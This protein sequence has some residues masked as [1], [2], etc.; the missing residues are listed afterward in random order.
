MPLRFVKD[1]RDPPLPTW[2]QYRAVLRKRDRTSLLLTAAQV[3][4]GLAGG[5]DP[6]EDAERYGFTHWS[7]GDVARMSL[8]WS[9]DT[10]P[11][12]EFFDLVQLSSMHVNLGGEGL[13]PGTQQIENFE[14]TMARILFQQAVWQRSVTGELA[15]T[16]LLFGE[17]AEFPGAYNVEVMT[18][19]WF[20]RATDGLTLEEY[21][22]AIF[23]ISATAIQAQ[24]Q[25][26]PDWPGQPGLDVVEGVFSPH[27]LR[28]VFEEHLVTTADDFKAT[29]RT[30]QD[31]L[32]EVQK[33]YA[34]NPLRDTPF[35]IGLTEVPFAPWVQAIMMKASP[36]GI[37][38]LLHDAGF[39]GFSND[40]GM[41][42]QEYVGRH[43]G[44]VADNDRVLSEIE[45]G[46]K[47]NRLDSCDWFLDLPGLL[48]LIECK[49][50]QPIESLRVAD[51]SWLDAITR[52]VGRGIAQ[53][54]RSAA[55]IEAINAAGRALDTT[56]PRIGLVVTLEPFFLNQLWVMR[57]HL[58]PAEFP[59]GVVSIED[60]ERL[61]T[62][63]PGELA[64][65]LLADA[66]RAVD[67]VL[68]LNESMGVAQQRG[69][70]NHLIEETFQSLGLFARVRDA[71]ERSAQSSVIAN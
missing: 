69:G 57:A 14:R 62:L 42:F 32:D 53:L 18:P 30:F 58:P 35:I 8:A 19:G 70:E 9:R 15:R 65:T 6:G 61:V 43:L 13:E 46:P 60:L 68:V 23:V 67:N 40:L 22:E 33:K 2:L 45:Y 59:V 24:G 27:I 41:V 7:I 1:D 54:N 44:L 50:L 66:E 17:S 47:K 5:I 25:F 28:R 63:T 51:Q 56:K 21:V 64:K 49:A 11:R 31:P 12:A 52:G 26:S 3:T 34:F 16:M 55:N 36:S 29:N 10:R 48:V 38:H 4:A 37:Y 71:R 20:Q 39:E